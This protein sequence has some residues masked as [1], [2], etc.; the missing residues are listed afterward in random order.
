MSQVVKLVKLLLVMPA[1][2]AISERLFS[3]MC[4]IKRTYLRSTM[5]QERLNPVMVLHIH[6]EL[7]N[8]L[9][10]NDICKEFISKSDY[11]KTKFSF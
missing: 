8:G 5:A 7:T 1:T 4:H 3:T 2:N 11:R 10:L 9:D 6:R